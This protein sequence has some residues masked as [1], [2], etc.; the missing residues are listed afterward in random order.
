MAAEKT[1]EQEPS[2]E[3]ILASIRQIISDDDDKDGES[4]LPEPVVEPVAAAP[5][6]ETPPPAP[7]E[8]VFEPA[9][10]DVFDSVSIEKEPEDDVLELT[11]PILD[12][13]AFEEE[14][15]QIDLQETAPPPQPAEV[16]MEKP[17]RKAAAADDIL[18]ETARSATI[19]SMAK[20]AGN[21]PITKH[22]EYGN[23]T[24]EDLVREMLHP[25]LRDWLSENLPPMVERVVQKELEKLARQAQDV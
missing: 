23:I 20:L 6:P 4:S 19:S 5:K 14:A 12:E 8:P 13:P 17:T 3:E 22:R 18:T 7:P 21:M 10:F 2:I 25:M 9:G 16:E 11:D 1:P 24:L 15:M